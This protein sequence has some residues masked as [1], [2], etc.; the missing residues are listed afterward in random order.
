MNLQ[1]PRVPQKLFD[2]GLVVRQSWGP[3][4]F[5]PD[6]A[7][8]FSNGREFKSTDSTDHGFYDS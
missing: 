7:Y 1:Y 5:E 3:E 8:K 2:W 4:Y 6:V